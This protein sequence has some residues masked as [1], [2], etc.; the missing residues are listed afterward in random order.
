MRPIRLGLVLLA[1]ALCGGLSLFADGPDVARAAKPKN[2][3]CL[4]IDFSGY[5]QAGGAYFGQFNAALA[6]RVPGLGLPIQ[7][8]LA[9]YVPD[10]T[11]PNSCND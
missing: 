7:L 3:A 4:G 2:Q 5:A 6:Q 11:V 9:G 1:L 8:H 10:S